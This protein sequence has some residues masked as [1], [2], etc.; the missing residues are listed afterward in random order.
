MEEIFVG[1]LGRRVP[2]HGQLKLLAGHALAVIGDG[3]PGFACAGKL[4]VDAR[5]PGVDGVLHQ[6]LDGRRGALDHLP[7]GDAVDKGRRQDTDRLGHG[8]HLSQRVNHCQ[9]ILA[10]RDGIQNLMSS[11]TRSQQAE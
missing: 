3:D 6:F 11:P 5:R 7:R 10:A 2:L 9:F 8:F 1:Q 4:H